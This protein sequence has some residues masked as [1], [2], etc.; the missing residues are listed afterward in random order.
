MISVENADLCSWNYPGIQYDAN[1]LA[2]NAIVGNRKYLLPANWDPEIQDCFMPSITGSTDIYVSASS[3]SS[4]QDGS[5]AH[6]FKDLSGAFAQNVQGKTIRLKKG[7]VFSAS[8]VMTSASNFKLT[9]YGPSTDKSPVITQSIKLTMDPTITGEEILNYDLS[10]IMTDSQSNS[11]WG[12]WVD[13]VRFMVARYPNMI[14]PTVRNGLDTSEFIFLQNS[15]NGEFRSN[16]TVD[17]TLKNINSKYWVGATLRIREGTWSYR[18]RKVTDVNNGVFTVSNQFRT[19]SAS[20]FFLENLYSE[21]DAPGEYYYNPQTKILSIYRCP[22]STCPA[23]GD[24]SDLGV[25]VL[26]GGSSNEESLGRENRDDYILQNPK[27]RFGKPNP[28]LSLSGSNIEIDG[29]EF[30]KSFFG[31]Y[32]NGNQIKI[33]NSVF[34]EFIN[35][36]IHYAPTASGSVSNSVI[37][38]ADRYGIHN[39][40][41]NY[42]TIINPNSL[43]ISDVQLRNI[44]LTAGYLWEGGAIRCGGCV[45]ERNTIESV[46]FSGIYALNNAVIRSNTITD[47]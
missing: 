36:A 37:S 19:M 29:I 18:R 25:W 21:L 7:D 9:S 1:N 40:P 12:V 31:V 33:G 32:A 10:L 43:T 23:S 28:S 47:W 16:V 15:T 41:D 39:G 34:N 30:K 27:D 6:P 44:G 38:N 26:P 46:G 8:S 22:A 17:P 13:G 20:G 5:M 24:P 42:L 14:D 3:L 11:I 4:I 2:Y 45:A 35:T